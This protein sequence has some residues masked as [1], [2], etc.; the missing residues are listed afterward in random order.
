MRFKLGEFKNYFNAISSL[1]CLWRWELT[2]L[3]PKQGSRLSYYYLGRK[4]QRDMAKA[5]L[6]IDGYDF[7][8]A[9]WHKVLVSEFP[10]PGALK[11]PQYLSTVL[12][13]RGRTLD[14]LLSNFEK[15]KR[16]FLRN[17]RADYDYRQVLQDEEIRRLD[18]EMIT[19]FASA[20]YG[21]GVVH[22]QSNDVERMAKEA[23]K[24]HLVSCDNEEVACHLGCE[25]IRNG[26][27]YWRGVRAGYPE[28]VYSDNKRFREANL[29]NTYIE[30]EWALGNGYDH[31]DVGISL[32]N[33]EDGVIQWKR[34][35]RGRLDTLGNYSYFYL[36]P[37]KSGVARFYWDTPVFAVENGGLV[38]HLGMP[39]AIAEPDLIARYKQM[40]FDGL[41]KVYLHCQSQAS[42]NLAGQVRSL[43]SSHENSPQ[44]IVM[45][46]SN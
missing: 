44:V 9:D 11:L 41:L 2:K 23:G 4:D 24:L 34:S 35:L 17:H 40:S 45:Q 19:P 29:M 26:E 32:A 25:F 28:A 6:S 3:P 43:Y 38:L 13:L 37:P 8:Q 39:D 7:E 33:P 10:I 1:A 31:Y 46:V 16:K 27:R 18:M 5:I 30:M 14:E 42:E 22:L 36:R 12:P 15:Q 20:R 21:D